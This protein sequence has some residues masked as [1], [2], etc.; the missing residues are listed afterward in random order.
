MT[1]EKIS[2]PEFSQFTELGLHTYG[3]EATSTSSSKLADKIVAKHTLVDLILQGKSSRS[4]LSHPR[5]AIKLKDYRNTSYGLFVMRINDTLI[6]S[7]RNGR[8]F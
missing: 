6:I 1:D 5:K 7:S 8:M 4:K 2:V 3:K